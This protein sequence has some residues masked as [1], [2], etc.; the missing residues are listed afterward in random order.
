MKII[1]FTYIC[2]IFI[3]LKNGYAD[4]MPSETSPFK[5]ANYELINI[6]ALKKSSEDLRLLFFYMPY[7]VKFEPDVNIDLKS[8]MTSISNNKFYIFT[9][10]AVNRYGYYRNFFDVN[11]SDPFFLFAYAW[12]Y[13]T[14]HRKRI[15]TTQ[16]LLCFKKNSLIIYPF[17]LYISGSLE[18]SR[19]FYDSTLLD[20]LHADAGDLFIVYGDPT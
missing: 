9:G 18:D 10:Y 11:S 13:W 2:F 1:I 17:S 16:Y 14:N 7:H 12:N 15:Y 20:I 6:E 4:N 3:L 5:E 8:W 19:N